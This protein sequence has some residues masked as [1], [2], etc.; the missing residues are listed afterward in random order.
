MSRID[1]GS[2]GDEPTCVGTIDDVG[3]VDIEVLTAPTTPPPHHF[4]LLGLWTIITLRVASFAFLVVVYTITRIPLPFL[5]AY[6]GPLAFRSFEFSLQAVL[7]L[8]IV[9]YVFF[10][11]C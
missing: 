2:V 7:L 4:A 6:N 5:S 10:F 9:V 8:L 11:V 3:Y 1:G